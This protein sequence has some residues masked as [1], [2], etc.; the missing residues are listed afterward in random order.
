MRILD[1][2]H[3]LD[4][5]A[6]ACLKRP[7]VMRSST[8]TATLPAGIIGEGVLRAPDHAPLV[9]D[10]P[11]LLLRSTAVKKRRLVPAGKVRRYIGD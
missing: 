9:L 11:H 6:K 2:R 3:V 8:S 5:R 7:A 1:T 10:A 4:G